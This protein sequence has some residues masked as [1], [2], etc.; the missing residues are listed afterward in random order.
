ME[1]SGDG[2]VPA[3]DIDACIVCIGRETVA[4]ADDG[5][6]PSPAASAAANA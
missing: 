5:C 3:V 4:A 1:R 2:R 6:T